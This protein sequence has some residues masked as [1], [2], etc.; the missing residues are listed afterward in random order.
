MIY[1]AGIGSRETP[2]QILKKMNEISAFLASKG[3]V[4]RSGGALGADSAFE[5][6][7]DHKNGLKE[8]FYSKDAT[9]KSIGIAM[10]YHPNPNAIKAKGDYVVA[11]QGRNIQ[12]I[13]GRELNQNVSFVVCWTKDG[14][15]SGGTGLGIRYALDNNIPVF[16]LYFDEDL[17]K[18][19]D[20]TLNLLNHKYTK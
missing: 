3:F 18:L 5:A 16:N 14:K 1:Y 2:R 12:I 9:E 15:D 11:L 7:C 10:N 6:G 19:R 17:A 4:L 20:F 8:I 13:S